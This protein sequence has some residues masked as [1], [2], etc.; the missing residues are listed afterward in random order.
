MATMTAMNYMQIAQ[1]HWR[2][3]RPTQYAAMTPQEREIF[4]EDL[5]EQ[6]Q[7]Q[8][9]STWLSLAGRDPA[10]ESSEQKMDRLATARANA[11]SAAIRQILLPG[12]ETEDPQDLDPDDLTQERLQD[13][14]E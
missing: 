3:W 11:E 9:A 12:P 6:V 13:Y 14:G 10:G 1:E 5:A 2:Q 7:E 4:F 8:V